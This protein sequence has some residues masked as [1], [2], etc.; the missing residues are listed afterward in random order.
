VERQISPPR[1]FATP[2]YNVPMRGDLLWVY[3]G[4]TEYFGDVLT[5]RSGIWTPEQYRD[6]LAATAADMDHR[7]GRVWRDL[8]DTADATQLLYYSPPDWNSSCARSD[9][10]PEG[11]LLWLDVDTI[12]REKSGGKKSLD[13]FA[14]AFFGTDD[15]SF[16]VKPYEFA[17]W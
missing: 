10:Y 5:A 1:R 16:A 4:L 6:E 14:R 15:G 8:Q 11:E 7:P 13:D 17:I 2:N 3:E 9:Y 12:I